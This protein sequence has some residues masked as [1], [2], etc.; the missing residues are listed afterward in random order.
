MTSVQSSS[1]V[2]QSCHILNLPTEL[3][4]EV[5]EWLK[6][7][8]L[9]PLRATCHT[10]YD[11]VQQKFV[12]AHFADKTFVA[13]FEPSLRVLEQISQHAEFAKSVQIV[14]FIVLQKCE[15]HE[16]A[17]ADRYGPVDRSTMKKEL[18]AR[19]MQDQ[20]KDARGKTRIT[21]QWRHTIRQIF[22]NFERAGAIFTLQIKAGTYSY[23]PFRFAGRKHWERSLDAVHCWRYD[24]STP[25]LLNA[26]MGAASNIR[27]LQLGDGDEPL[28]F[29]GDAWCESLPAQELASSLENLRSLDLR[30]DANG[31]DISSF[32]EYLTVLLA[33]IPQLRKLRFERLWAGTIFDFAKGV[34]MPCL[35]EAE[36]DTC[37]LIIEEVVAF[38]ERHRESLKLLSISGVNELGDDDA[39]VEKMILEH[40]AAEVEGH[41]VQLVVKDLK[42]FGPLT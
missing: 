22:Q 16:I 37:H 40:L 13:W 24:A 18:S 10:I 11:T 25:E 3:L 15:C 8:D 23:K 29:G 30:F 20:L 28:F 32:E 36:F 39:E 27:N 38:V 12:K 17:H 35:E 5:V 1:Q 2:N 34:T 19:E 4:E 31:S 41:E 42:D 33:S 9:I 21:V 14:R 7:E 6:P 26:I